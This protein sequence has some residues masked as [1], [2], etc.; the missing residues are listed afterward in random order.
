VDFDLA[1]IIGKIGHLAP[2]RIG[3]AKAGDRLDV[4]RAIGRDPAV[5]RAER[6]VGIRLRYDTG[7]VTRVDADRGYHSVT[8]HRRVFLTVCS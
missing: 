8:E 6:V 4:K 2:G 7:K 1:H 5:D 3:I